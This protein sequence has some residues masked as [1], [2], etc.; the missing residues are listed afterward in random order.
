MIDKILYSR[1]KIT[2]GIFCFL[3]L[4]RATDFFVTDYTPTIAYYFALFITILITA[5]IWLNKEQLHILH[6]DKY[7]IFLFLILGVLT[8]MVYGATWL[9]VSGCASALFIIYLLR[10]RSLGFENDKSLMLLILLTAL[11]IMPVLLFRLLA[12]EPSLFIKNF[13]ALDGV[14]LFVLIFRTL[15]AVIYEEVLFRGLLWMFLEKLK[16]SG[17]KILLIQGFLYWIVHFNWMPRA[18]FWVLLPILSLWL[19]FLVL[20]SKSLVPSISAHFIWNLILY[21]I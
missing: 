11:G 17:M 21:L 18:S 16:L 7:F 10:K 8:F 5:L 3:L 6:I 1:N 14:N 9:G 20:K 12:N 2:F 13:F 15:H 19:G 4:L